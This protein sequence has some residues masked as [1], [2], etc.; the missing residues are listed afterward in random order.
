MRE[1]AER[2]ATK[3][4]LEDR[5]HGDIRGVGKKERNLL[6]WLV[7]NGTAV[8]GRDRDFALLGID[9]PELAAAVFEADF[10]TVRHF[11]PRV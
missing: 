2:S 4:L 11:L 7:G 9:D 1:S 3:G 6:A 5:V 8:W 10:S